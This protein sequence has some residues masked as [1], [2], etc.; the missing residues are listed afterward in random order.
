MRKT[1]EILNALH[2]GN[3]EGVRL[4]EITAR[5]RL[6]RPTVFRILRT[7]ESLG[8]ITLD[9]KGSTYTITERLTALGQPSAGTRLT[10]VARPSMARLL[11]AFSQTVSL[12]MLEHGKIIRRQ[13]M[14]GFLA[15]ARRTAPGVVASPAQ[16]ASGKAILAFMPA[17]RITA[18]VYAA[19]NGYAPNGAN[20]DL[21]RLNREF[22]Q[23]RG[24]GYAVD[25]EQTE[26]GLR[27]VGAPIFDRLGEPVGAISVSGSDS[28]IYPEIIPRM[29]K[30]LRK[31]CQ[32]ISFSLG[33]LQ[34]GGMCQT[35]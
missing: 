12:V 34:D 10:E 27:C 13:V 19:Q 17:P 33:Y 26:K 35:K 2:S 22:S 29:G 18:L 7:L 11:T 6:P 30:Q 24:L 5:M 28:W 25:N 16:T 21:R 3:S 23:I 20:G 32:E 8:Y 14:E 9:G 1:F 31:E 4:S 15:I